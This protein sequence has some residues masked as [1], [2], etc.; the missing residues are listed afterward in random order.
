MADNVKVIDDEGDVILVVG[1]ADR[2]RTAANP[3]EIPS[4]EDDQAAMT[5]LWEL[6]HVRD[7]PEPPMYSGHSWNILQF[8]IITD[9]YDLT[10]PMRLQSQGMLLSWADQYRDKVSAADWKALGDIIAAAY[11]LGE[12]RAFA[13]VTEMWVR[14]DIR[15]VYFFHYPD[16][17]DTY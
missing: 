14:C 10:G 8:A 11:I 5:L 16:D 2:E 3:A 6:L 12:R 7:V 4:Q 1:R 17:F 13:R 9:K 15:L